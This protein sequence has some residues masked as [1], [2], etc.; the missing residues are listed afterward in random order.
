MLVLLA[1]GCGGSS[2]DSVQQVRGVEYGFNAPEG[3]EVTRSGR[4]VTASS[5]SEGEAVSVT[6]FQ[7]DR[8]YRARLDAQVTQE[9]NRVERSLAAKLGG[10]AGAPSR[11]E[12]ASRK[13]W[14]YRLAGTRDGTT[15][16]GFV[17][18]GRREY[19]LLCRGPADGEG[20][21]ELFA[22]FRLR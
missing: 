5:G 16:I 7:L 17:L 1:A 4:T 21:R 6:R 15:R 10:T 13:A 19:Q 14:A 18:V 20:C 12:I 2:D 8:A 11:P 3:W 22:T 9:L